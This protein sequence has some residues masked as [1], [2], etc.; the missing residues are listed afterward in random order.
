MGEECRDFPENVGRCWAI[1]SVK[2]GGSSWKSS[3]FSM[4]IVI[5]IVN[6]SPKFRG[7]FSQATYIGVFNNPLIRFV[8]AGH[9]SSLPKSSKYLVR[10]ARLEP[11]SRPSPN[12]HLLSSYLENEGLKAPKL[13]VD[14]RVCFFKYVFKHVSYHMCLYNDV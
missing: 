6:I 5:V 12:S 11:L 8:P 13:T 4:V 7:T 9:P 1:V 3:D 2:L 10:R 14:G